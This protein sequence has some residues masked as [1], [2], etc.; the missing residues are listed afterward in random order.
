MMHIPA[1]QNRFCVHAQPQG[2]RHAFRI[3]MPVKIDPEVDLLHK[4]GGHG[5]D[6]SVHMLRFIP[7]LGFLAHTTFQA[8]GLK[9]LFNMISFS[10][11]RLAILCQT[12]EKTAE[13]EGPADR[14]VQ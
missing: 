5:Q 2:A 13:P 12:N 7:F 11:R 14:C 3:D 4:G 1:S 6:T 10:A 8:D 9:P